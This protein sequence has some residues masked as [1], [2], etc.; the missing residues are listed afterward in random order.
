M[1][2]F[3]VGL[4]FSVASTTR[5]F[6]SSEALS[7]QENGVFYRSMYKKALPVLLYTSP[8]KPTVFFAVCGYC[9]RV[10]LTAGMSRYSPHLG[11]PPTHSPSYVFRVDMYKNR[12]AKT[13]HKHIFRFYLTTIAVIVWQMCSMSVDVDHVQESR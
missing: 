7:D 6:S 3:V 10:S 9:L 12:P 5:I 2:G 4:P 1:R 11:V 13:K 8:S